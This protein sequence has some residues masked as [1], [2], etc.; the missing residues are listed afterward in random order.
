MQWYKNLN[1]DSGVAAF[2]IGADYILVKFTGTSRTYRYSYLKAGKA[3]VEQMKILAQNGRGLNAY[4]NMHVKFK[5][6]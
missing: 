1:G 6:D 3:H 5:Y 4:I 2:E